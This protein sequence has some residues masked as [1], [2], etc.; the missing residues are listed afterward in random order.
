MKKK[1]KFQEKLDRN[2]VRIINVISF[3]MGFS[4]SI[5]IYTVS[6]YFKEASGVENVGIFYFISFAAVL[7]ILLN[8]Y[9]LTQK[10]GSIFVFHLSMVANVAFISALIIL[11]K[12]L[13][14]VAAMILYLISVSITWASL[15]VVLESFSVDKMSGRIRGLYLTLFNA[16]FVL[17][18]LLA[19]KLLVQYDFS[20]MFFVSLIFAMFILLFSA[21]GLRGARN[22]SF[23]KRKEGIRKLISKSLGQKNISRIYYISFVLDFFY[24]LMIVYAPIYLLDR[25]FSWD[26]LG[27]AFTIMLIPFV[28]VQY[29]AGILADK[30]IGEK[31]MIILAILVMGIS[32]FLF[33]LSSSKDILVWAVILFATRVG[34][35][36]VEIL[37]DSYF[38][39]Q[40]DGSRADVIDFFRTAQPVAYIAAAVFS[41][42]ILWTF[43]LKYVFLL[44][45][46]V[47][48]SALWPALRLTDSQ[49]EES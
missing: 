36:L 46:L 31:E 41:T 2:K 11:P 9:K 44:L 27:I 6:T 37:R 3:L 5:L 4:Q 49:V 45:A 43:P 10:T 30:K 13:W 18:P 48:F 22:V 21:F 14:G 26:Q 40:V 39:K 19:S 28:L 42:L 29:P 47:I 12:T 15:D 1:S 32:S 8:L 35:A 17:G 33:F 34:A 38:Y 7:F 25:G 23:P 16:G 20:G 24:A